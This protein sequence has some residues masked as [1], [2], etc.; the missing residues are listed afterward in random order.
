MTQGT[1]RQEGGG[2]L[3]AVSNE[4]FYFITARA[5]LVEEP[6]SAEDGELLA[7]AELASVRIPLISGGQPTKLLL[8][9]WMVHEGKNN[10]GLVFRASDLEAFAPHLSEPNLLPMDWSHSAVLGQEGLPKALGVWYKASFE[11]DSDAYG[12]RGAFGLRAQGA[13]WAWAFPD[14]AAKMIEEYRDRG[15]VEFSMAC[16]PTRLEQ[17]RD[18]NGEYSIA[19]EPVF[20]TLSAL[21]R[22]LPPGDP[23]AVGRITNMLDLPLLASDEL[24][25]A[26]DNL[27]DG[28][29]AAL[30]AARIKEESMDE[31]ITQE[32]MQAVIDAKDT[33]KS[34]LDQLLATH[35]QTSARIA[36]LETQLASMTTRAEEA[37][38]K[39]DALQAEMEAAG[40]R[41]Q[42]I[43]AQLE[44]A[45]TQLVAIAAEQEKAAVEER[46]AARFEELPE[47]YR[48]AFVKRSDDE[49]ARFKA[50]WAVASDEAWG[51]FKSDLF[52]GFAEMKLSYL[53]LSEEEGTLPNG[54]ISDLGAKVTALLK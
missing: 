38:L 4:P 48:V 5:R 30:Q 46:W 42:E 39:R 24:P 21:P 23:D 20:F 37:E 22:D 53:K 44:T 33:L 40:S 31:K 52:V 3:S 50:R 1:R 41:M 7:K 2:S 32:A 29:V 6:L 28:G 14:Y 12:G 11:W 27:D 26:E 54:S 16:I 49:Q 43:T 19:I 47:S 15:F 25:G 34:Q 8:D 35:E 45:N 17:G 51:E 13:M 36:D 10:N 18:H 9:A